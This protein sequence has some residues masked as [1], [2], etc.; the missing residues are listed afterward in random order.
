MAHGL[1]ELFYRRLTKRKRP[2][3][4]LRLCSIFRARLFGEEGVNK[5]ES[6][7]H[8]LNTAHALHVQ[9]AINTAFQHSSIHPFTRKRERER[10]RESENV[11][12]YKEK[13]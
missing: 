8:A 9:L 5:F 11:D 1:L 6:T 13:P 2:R 3:Q 4:T 10:A 12:L 7:A